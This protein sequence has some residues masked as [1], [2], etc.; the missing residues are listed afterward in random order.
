[1]TTTEETTG[2]SNEPDPV[3]L[4]FRRFAYFAKDG[5]SHPRVWNSLY[6]FIAIS[7][8]RNKGANHLDL[9]R[10][11]VEFGLPEAKAIEY[12]EIYWHGRCILYVR[13]HPYKRFDYLGWV[14][15]GTS[16]LT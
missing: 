5:S 14:R 4:A 15:K 12:S 2:P 13:S 7:H 6:R 3:E 11:L 16:C 1:M 8:A 10:R 9:R